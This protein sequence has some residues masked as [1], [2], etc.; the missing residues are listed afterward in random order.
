MKL[1]FTK[2]LAANIYT[3]NLA[4]EDVEETDTDLFA[5]FGEPTVNIGGE[6]KSGANTLATLPAN[7]RKIV[8][9]MPVIIRFADKDYSDGAKA[10]A[11]AWILT[12]ESRIN[13]EVT[14]LRA[15]SDDFSGTEESII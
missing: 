12:I 4:I 15:K 10:V 9:Q 13:A 5:D 8:T 1:V 14:A 3:V 11:E 7:F 2:T 6:I